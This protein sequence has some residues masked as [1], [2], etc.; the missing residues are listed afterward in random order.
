MQSGFAKGACLMDAMALGRF[1]LGAIWVFF[2]LG[3]TMWWLK[4][5]KGLPFVKNPDTWIK[6]LEVYPLGLRNKI[7][8]IEVD[9]QRL[10]LSVGAQEVK[11]LHAWPQLETQFFNSTPTSNFAH[12]SSASSKDSR[13]NQG[14]ALHEHSSISGD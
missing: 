12:S 14:G 11:T 5:K 7:M 4:K 1:A 10:L 8:F 3:L 2:L 6:V 9:G 13:F